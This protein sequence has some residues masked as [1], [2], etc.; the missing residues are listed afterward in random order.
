[1]P[2]SEDRI[3]RFQPP[4]PSQKFQPNRYNVSN[5]LELLKD[6]E[7]FYN[8][9]YRDPYLKW[10]VGYGTLI[11]DGSDEA[12]AASKYAKEAKLSLND[13]RAFKHTSRRF[14]K[15][16][17]ISQLNGDATVAEAQK[18]ALGMAKG[19]AKNKL[20]RVR[21]EGEYG[22]PP[23]SE[24]GVDA[25][26]ALPR[27]LQNLVLSS[28]YRGGITGSP[29]TNKLIKD[30]DFIAASAEFLNSG[31]YRRESQPESAAPGVAIRMEKL[32]TAL[33]E[34]GEDM[35]RNWGDD[36]IRRILGK[37]PQGGSPQ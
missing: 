31:E 13:I 26:D 21:G 10:T 25:F 24:M 36:T 33:R 34:H 29:K 28:A 2:Q 7:G 9:P 4:S 27:K 22:K 6:E 17:S 32:S 30:G 15:A 5:V 18:I 19:E 8:H 12:F 14:R 1:M 16:K 37:L 3:A 11:G 23:Y 20:K 35:R